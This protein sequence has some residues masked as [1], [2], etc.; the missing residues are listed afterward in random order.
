MGEDKVSGGRGEPELMP[1]GLGTG[2]RM[3]KRR[4]PQKAAVPAPVAAKK[5]AVERYKHY[6]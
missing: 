5:A 4:K 6:G 3:G 1:L 2:A